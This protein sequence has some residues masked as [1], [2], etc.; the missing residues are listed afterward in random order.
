MQVAERERETARSAAK[1]RIAVVSGVVCC[2]VVSGDPVLC[3]LV[4]FVFFLGCVMRMKKWVSKV[5]GIL[6]TVRNWSNNFS[7]NLHLFDK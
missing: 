7:C 6:K 2:G 5:L 4:F 1:R 3:L